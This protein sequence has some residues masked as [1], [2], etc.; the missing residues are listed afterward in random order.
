MSN[1][2]EIKAARASARAMHRTWRE[3]LA[4]LTALTITPEAIT[5]RDDLDAVDDALEDAQLSL[6]LLGAIRDAMCEA[7]NRMRIATRTSQTT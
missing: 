7:T 2:D 3:E 4:R 1:S 6:E 5:K